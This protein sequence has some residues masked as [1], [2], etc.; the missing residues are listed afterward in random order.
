MAT[1]RGHLDTEL[2]GYIMLIHPSILLP[3]LVLGE[4]VQNDVMRYTSSRATA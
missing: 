3:F 2:L 1:W 4:F